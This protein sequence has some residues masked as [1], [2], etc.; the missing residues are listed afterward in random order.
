MLPGRCLESG[1]GDSEDWIVGVDETLS[2]NVDASSIA[3]VDCFDDTVRSKR[4]DGLTRGALAHRCESCK[5]A[6][7]EIDLRIIAEEVEDMWCRAVFE[8]IP[9]LYREW[10]PNGPRQVVAS[11]IVFAVFRAKILHKEFYFASIYIFYILLRV[12]K[13]D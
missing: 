2:V 8:Q 7:G 12:F 1:L 3:V 9:L 4:I 11:T 6:D 10:I 5:L 13:V